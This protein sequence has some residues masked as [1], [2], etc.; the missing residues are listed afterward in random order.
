MCVLEK[1]GVFALTHIGNHSCTMVA[2]QPDT[3]DPV[4]I[5]PTVV[6]EALGEPWSSVRCQQGAKDSPLV[7][8]TPWG[9]RSEAAA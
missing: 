3:E 7:P 1:E 4:P 6:A 8:L 9:T 2:T 5:E